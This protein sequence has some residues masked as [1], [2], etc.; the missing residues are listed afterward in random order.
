MKW[1][2]INVA[3]NGYS[4]KSYYLIKLTELTINTT[5]TAAMATV[6][7]TDND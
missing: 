7:T 5:T 6:S 3:A 1:T 2:T 4:Y